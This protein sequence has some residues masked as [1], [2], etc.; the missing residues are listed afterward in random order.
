MSD[1]APVRHAPRVLREAEFDP[2]VVDYWLLSGAIIW[3]IFIVTI[4]V[5]ILWYLL[6]R[7]IC[8]KILSHMSCT[9]TTRNLQIRKGWL[10][11]VEKTVPLEKITDLAMYQGPIMRAMHLKGFRVETAGAGGSTTGYLVSMVG[12]RD[13]DDFREAVLAQRDRVSGRED[14]DRGG[15]TSAPGGATDAAL[16]EAVRDLHRTVERIE[17]KLDRLG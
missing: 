13:C 2:R 11:R 5:A 17:E 8:L 12:I 9:L 4:P 6:G 16:V 3:A 1:D 7:P 14:E 15:G 10:N